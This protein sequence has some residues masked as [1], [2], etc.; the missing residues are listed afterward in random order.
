M[1]AATKKSAVLIAL[2]Q[3]ATA[4]PSFAAAGEVETGYLFSE[5]REQDIPGS[6]TAIGRDESRYEIQ[7]HLFN[8]V[9]PLETSSVSLDLT[10]ETMSGASPWYVTPG[11]DGKPVQV[12]SG[13]S[14]REE[15]VDIQGKWSKPVKG[16]LVGLSAGY[17]TEDD[18]EAVNGGLEVEFENASKALTWSGGVG[19][20]NDKLEPTE[21]GSTRFPSRITEADRESWK[22]YG[23]TA[24]VID[25]NTVVQGSVSYTDSSG[26][27]SDPYKQAWIQSFSNVVSDSRPDGRR[28]F[29][30]TARLRHKVEAANAAL[31]I[32]YRFHDDDWEIQS[33]TLEASWYQRLSDT[34]TLTPAIRWYSQGQAFFYEPYYAAPRSDGFASSDY[35]LSPFGALSG[36]I[37]VSKAIGAWNIAAGFEYYQ[38]DERFALKEVEV[39]NPGL[40]E[41]TSL[42]FRV[43]RVF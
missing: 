40:V 26:Y 14:I 21:G 1:A 35:R 11:T 17:S 13:A 9:A 37:D 27:L 20:S 12:M 28:S 19:Y 38:A 8:I 41:Y 42:Q 16:V 6:R 24:L 5:Y 33:H 34:W 18:Y 15:R 32:D 10:Y 22:L 31:H 43:R 30:F 3:A 36:R 39:E 23:G 29:A 7:S 25:A 2:T 4:L